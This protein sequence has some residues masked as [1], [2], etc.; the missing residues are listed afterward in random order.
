M[1]NKQIGK[2]GEDLACK[3]LV[4]HEF[5]ILDRNYLKKYGE[6]DIVAK[7]D[8]K[9]HFVEVKTVTRENLNNSRSF[10][11]HRPEDNVHPYKLRRLRRVIQVYL[12]QKRLYGDWQFD[13]ITV[14][15]D[16]TRKEAR[17][18]FLEDLI[19]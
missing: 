4:K 2:I 13:V 3:F 11:Q 15:Y 18:E 1:W 16:P 14:L 10:N 19:L 9:I 12:I 17:V 6:I 5:D 7:K 8:G